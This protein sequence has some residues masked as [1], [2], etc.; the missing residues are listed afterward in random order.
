MSEVKT[1]ILGAANNGMVK[2]CP[3]CM[4]TGFHRPGVG[5]NAIYPDTGILTYL[6]KCLKCGGK[7][8]LPDNASDFA[9]K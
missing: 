1:K 7:G 3:D 9:Q 6:P 5:Y 2:L 8:W 4:G